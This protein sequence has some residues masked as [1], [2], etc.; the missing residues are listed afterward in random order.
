MESGTTWVRAGLLMLA[1]AVVPAG[2]SAQR[3]ENA[4]GSRLSDF[5]G[6]VELDTRFG[7]MMGEFAAFAGARAAL[8]LKQHLYLG[9]GGSGLA[10]DNA[11]VQG[12]TPG[13]P[14][15]L[16]MGY[17]GFLIGYAVPTREFLDLTADVLIGGG[18]LSLE[19]LD[20]N[21]A[22]FVFEPS[23]GVELRV[24]PVVRL[25]LGAGYR[26]VGDADLQGVTDSDLRGFTGTASIRIGWF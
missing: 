4:V 21:D 2:V 17:G 23:V 15:R 8:R 5:G 3:A 1:A 7:D 16:N 25:G 6:F 20:Q 11:L 9:L 24:A 14:H 19:G 18:G 22:L 12:G 26:F 10:T 13:T